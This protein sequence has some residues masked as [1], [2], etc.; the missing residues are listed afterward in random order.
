MG[1]SPLRFSRAELASGRPAGLWPRPPAPEPLHG[2]I[3]HPLSS[4]CWLYRF[5]PVA[6]AERVPRGRCLKAGLWLRVLHE[7]RQ[8]ALQLFS[9]TAYG[10]DLSVPREEPP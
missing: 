10:H 9:C 6:V 7:G 2:C 3:P 1:D 4:T 8:C 5:S